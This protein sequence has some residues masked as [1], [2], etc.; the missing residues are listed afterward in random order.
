MASKEKRWD[1]PLADMIHRWS[2]HLQT[3]SS[4]CR[5]PRLCPISCATVVAM[6]PTGELLSCKRRAQKLLY[7]ETAHTRIWN[8]AHVFSVVIRFTSRRRGESRIKRCTSPVFQSVRLSVRPGSQYI[9]P[10][11]PITVSG[12]VEFCND[13]SFVFVAKRHFGSIQCSSHHYN[14]AE[15]WEQRVCSLKLYQ[16]LLEGLIQ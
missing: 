2:G 10:W 6:A 9:Y 8:A 1:L 13:L 15:H 4:S 3:A 11:W 12:N 16:Y 7:I 14:T 5:K